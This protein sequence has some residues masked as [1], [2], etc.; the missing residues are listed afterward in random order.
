MGSLGSLGV[1]GVH[2]QVAARAA[3][4][5]YV[6][7]N[8]QSGDDRYAFKA[9]SWRELVYQVKAVDKGGSGKRA[10]EIASRVDVLLTDQPLTITGFTHMLTRRMSDVDYP[11]DI[12]GEMYRHSGGLFVIGIDPD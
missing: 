8:Q 4:E 6:V 11:E 1:T 10:G 3:T 2:E 5:P 9:R 7:F 12:G